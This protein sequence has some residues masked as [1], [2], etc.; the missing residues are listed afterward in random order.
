MRLANFTD[1]FIQER[2]YLK[3]VSPA[4]LDW[5][6]YSFKA[7]EPVLDAEL[8]TSTIKQAVIAHIDAL[9]RHGRGNK[10]VSINTYLR[11]FKTFF[12][13]VS[14]GRN[15]QRANQT[16]V[17]QRREQNPSDVFL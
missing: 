11:C 13:V 2:K 7:F 14:H 5:Y 3:G 10:N 17:A 16:I 9:Q 4:T 15:C 1:A 8:E 12:A 6:K